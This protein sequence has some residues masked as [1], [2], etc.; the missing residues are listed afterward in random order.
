VLAAGR[1]LRF[2]GAIPKPLLE[3]GGRP[4]VAHAVGAAIASGLVPVIVV[5]SDDR[6]ADALGPDA[7]GTGARVTI[8]RNDAPERGISSSLHTALRT[9]APEA[10]VEAVVVGLADQ[11]LMGSDAYRRVSGAYDAGAQL[12]VATYAGVRGNPVLIGRTHWDE[13][14]AL[15]GDE[16]ARVLLRRHGAVEVPCDGTGSPADVDTPEDLIALEK[17]WRSQTTSE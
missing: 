2:G 15:V 9:L 3:L 17:L 12:A 7:L 10:A 5:V 14:L 8:A 16:G 11:P 13:A 4:L 6:V 1:G